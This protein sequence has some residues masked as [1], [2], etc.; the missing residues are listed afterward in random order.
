M[1]FVLTTKHPVSWTSRQKAPSGSIPG[2]LTARDYTMVLKVRSKHILSPDFQEKSSQIK[3]SAK[4][5]K[6]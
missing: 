3:P 1:I 5:F 2:G 6:N 4:P